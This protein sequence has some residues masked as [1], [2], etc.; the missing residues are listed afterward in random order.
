MKE[1]KNDGSFFACRPSCVPIILI[2]VFV[3][4]VVLFP[5]LNDDVWGEEPWIASGH[6]NSGC[7]IRLVESIPQG[8]VY[9][10]RAPA[11][12]STFQAWNILLQRAKKSVDISALYFSLKRGDEM[13]TRDGRDPSWQGQAILE[14]L[15]KIGSRLP[16]RIAQSQPRKDSPDAEW[17]Y[18]ANASKTEVR[19]LNMTKWFGSGV[20]HTKLWVI[21]KRDFYVGSANMDWRSL[22]EVKEL[23]A[24]VTDCPCLAQDIGKIFEVYWAMGAEGARLP[25]SWP[26]RLDT[27]FNADNPLRVALNASDY[28]S[29]FSS[30]P[31]GFSPKHR[32]DDAKAIVRHI[33]EARN[34]VHVAVMDYDPVT[35]YTPH[36]F[37]W[38]H[39]DTALRAAAFR[40]CDVRLLFSHWNHTHED[41]WAYLRS[42]AAYARIFQSKWHSG[43]LEIRMFTVNS[44]AEQAK[45]P[46][47]RVNHNKYMVTETAGFVGT[48]NWA[49]DYFISTGGIG[50]TLQATNSSTRTAFDGQSQVSAQPALGELQEIFLRDWESPYAKPLADFPEGLRPSAPSSDWERE[51]RGALW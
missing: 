39:I 21:D 4:L 31:P 29:F 17:R 41:M 5:V 3:A 13:G 6:C 9:Q 23:G 51:S 46:F 10:P 8:L 37:Y 14:S 24:L 28:L 43:S 33:D 50:F 26:A 34:Y 1:K 2:V 27:P 49:A 15:R 48:S 19:N 45:I 22:T 38:A 25:K 30:S 35:L 11:H 47:A 12:L 36:N 40:G 7:S 16:L 42:L 44:T 32:Q 20:L 18:L